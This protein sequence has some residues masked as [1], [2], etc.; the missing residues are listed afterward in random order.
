MSKIN[1]YYLMCDEKAL[2]EMREIQ[3]E[4]ANHQDCYQPENNGWQEPED[5]DNGYQS[6][7]SELAKEPF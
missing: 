7:C 1:N 3:R 4:I 2:D 5:D 6:H